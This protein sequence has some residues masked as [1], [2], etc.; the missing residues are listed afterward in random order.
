MLADK[1]LETRYTR[2][3]ENL[4]ELAK[5]E[6]DR[7][8]REAPEFYEVAQMYVENLSASLESVEQ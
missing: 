8:Q 2:H 5:K 3:L 6:L 1:L 7:T 4:I